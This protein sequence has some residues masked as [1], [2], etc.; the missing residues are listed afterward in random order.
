MSDLLELLE[1]VPGRGPE[2]PP[3]FGAMLDDISRAFGAER[4]LIAL[5]DPERRSLRGTVGRNVPADLVE[6][7]QVP[8][9]ERDDPLV[10][11]LRSGIPQRVRATA[12]DPRIGPHARDILLELGFDKFVVASLH[13][14]TESLGVLLIDRKA[15]LTDQDLEALVPA[16]MQASTEIQRARDVDRLRG[17]STRDAVEREWLW[18]MVNSVADPIVVSDEQ[19]QLVLQNKSAE[20]LFRVTAADVPGRAHAVTMNNV[21]FTAA[22]SSWNLE[23]GTVARPREI[24]LVDPVEGSDL[25]FEVIAQPATNYRGGERGMVCVLK[26]V[27]ELRLVSEELTRNVQRL[28]SADQEMRLERDRLDLILRSVPNPIIVIDSDDQAVSMNA[29]AQRLFGAPQ[30]LGG[31]VAAGR[32]QDLELRNNAKLASFIAQLRLDPGVRKSGEIQVVDPESEEQLEMAVISTEIRDDVGVPVATVTVMQDVGR[33]RELERRRLEQALFDSEKLAATGRLAAS[34]AHEINNPLEAIHNSLYLLV[35]KSDPSDPDHKFLAI[36]MKETERMSR[37][38]RQMLGFYRPAAA[39]APTDVNALVDEAESLVAKR[40]RDRR[41]RI[42]KELDPALPKVVAS[43]DQLKQVILNLM[44][45]AAEAMPNGGTITVSTRALGGGGAR[46]L[47]SD[48]VQIQIRDEGVGIP[49]E[50][51][52]QLFEPFFSTKGEKGTGLGLWVSYG[53]VQAHGGSLQVRSR[54]GEGTT[55]NITLPIGGPASG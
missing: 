44:L 12:T 8:L 29:A 7:L 36:A 13:G 42:V 18:W 28:Q 33:Y 45:N 15:E 17:A 21:L 51:M 38:L 54:E 53:I 5:Y 10:S 26:N 24:T 2:A 48:A 6:A 41:S 9:T 43:S 40:L 34:I 11:A 46:I 37:I 20:K 4:T 25:I 1:R 35:N 14:E 22:L 49:E 23:R 3:E 32:R 47:R 30:A 52:S 39:M 27:T 31:P 19:N 50:H 55:F 16:A